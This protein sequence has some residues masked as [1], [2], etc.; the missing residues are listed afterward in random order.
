MNSGDFRLF[1]HSDGV[2]A[3][4]PASGGWDLPVLFVDGVLAIFGFFWILM[5]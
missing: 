5:V 3:V 2:S 4:L 1:L